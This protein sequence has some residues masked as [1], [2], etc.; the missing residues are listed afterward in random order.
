[1]NKFTTNMKKMF[2]I[3]SIIYKASKPYFF[4]SIIKNIFASVLPFISLIFTNLIIDGLLAKE[5]T[6][7]I[8][9]YVFW[10]ITLNL[11]IGIALHIIQ[12]YL[13]N[14]STKFLYH[15]DNL[16]ALK[17]FE[18]DYGQIESNEVMKLIRKAEEGSNSSGGI[19]Y[20]AEIVF[21]RFL[22]SILKIINSFVLLS[23]L[24]KVA[25]LTKPT[26]LG[27][28][29][30]SPITIIMLILIMLLLSLINMF[31]MKK[32]N[33]K[34]YEAMMANI[35]GNRKYGYFYQLCSNYKYGKDIRI[36]KMQ[37][38]ILEAMTDEK[39][40]VDNNWR[41]FYIYSIKCQSLITL[42]NKILTFFAYLFVGLKAIYGLIS[43]GNVVAYATAITILF[44]QINLLI[45]T[46]QDVVLRNNYL[47]N[48]FEYLKLENKIN[49]G[50]NEI[51]DYES[52]EIEFKDLSFAYPNQ[53]LVL[54][55]IN[56]KINKGEKIAIVGSNGAGKTTLIK[57]LCRLYEPTSGDI[58]INGLP[59][60]SYSKESCYKLFSIVFQDF[61]L[62]SYSIK[63]NVSS[64]LD[65]DDEK[66]WECL[67]K[68]GI[69]ERV[70][71][72]EDKLDTIIYQRNR[73]NGVEISGGEA[74][75][76]AIARALYKD[77]P[78]VILDEPT[79]A[80]DPKSEAE[81]YEKFND[82]VKNKTSIFISHRMSSCK[83]CDR[84]IVIDDG[85]ILEEGTH[86]ELLNLNGL[87]N[88]MW[89]AQAKYYEE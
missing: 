52:I 16:I 37:N 3:L 60:S 26:M 2:Q 30:N 59:I 7:E 88:R 86:K 66:V 75:K 56:L 72:M 68:A 77:S 14:H 6:T 18:L 20:Y 12:Y 22:A 17:S 34:S 79:A 71:K 63:N 9:T 27:K 54:K 51:N 24:F 31:I 65:G 25:T 83:F 40:S 23:G 78:L 87:Y 45:Q 19:T 55:N 70:M 28:I 58:L 53:D 82:L 47:D 21:G 42:L 13:Q 49:F 89:N 69:K 1:M 39:Y 10:L 57:L 36:Y 4:L 33:K 80:L 85:Q 5:S 43:I 48:Y 32:V 11:V 81:I 67:D 29:V 62:F 8:L 50:L 74:Q 38:M 64:S 15:L 61:K 46:Y 76:L 41:S 35:D 44:S 73:K 84:I